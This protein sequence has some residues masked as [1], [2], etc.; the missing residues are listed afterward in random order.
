MSWHCWLTA[1]LLAGLAGGLSCGPVGY[2][3]AQTMSAAAGPQQMIPNGPSAA[4]P[5]TN[6]AYPATNAPVPTPYPSTGSNLTSG[7]YPATGSFPATA[8]GVPQS[9]V[10]PPYANA[11][12]NRMASTLNAPSTEPWPTMP[13]EPNLPT[14]D[15]LSPSA[16]PPASNPPLPSITAT[17]PD[18]LDANAYIERSFAS[19][20][21]W[22]WQVL[23]TGLMYKS[24]LAGNREPRLGSQW[25]HER[26][27]GWLWDGTIGGRVGLLRFGTN[28]DFW[29]QGWQL[30]TEAAA[31][32]R[33]DERRD[34]VSTDFRI[35]APLTTRQGPWEAKIGYVHFC[36]HL[37]DEFLLKNPGYSRI[38]YVRDSVVTG[39]AL[40][41]NPS[42]RLYSEAGYSFAVDDGAEPWEFQ[43]GADFSSTEPTG[44]WGAPFVAINGHLRQENDFGG[45]LTLQTGWQWRGRTGHLFRLGMQYF[46]GMSE[47][48]QFYDRFEE[49]LGAGLWYDF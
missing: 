7:S 48:A 31:F 20:E 32:P 42:L 38:N 36:S 28:N 8:A 9:V 44:G 25:V 16:Y 2:I 18:P 21:T 30:D 12:P 46:N 26:D 41:L 5:S 4:Y 33:L 1:L 15:G 34:V 22:S 49:Q 37:V 43:F 47:Q 45:N 6:T 40:Y 23:P 11:A 13:G 3:H 29:P 19:Q 39:L 10:P 14:Y 24:Y 17:S 27:Q 35:G